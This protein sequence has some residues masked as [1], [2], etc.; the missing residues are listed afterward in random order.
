MALARK[1]AYNVVFNSTLKVVSTVFIAL[2][3]IR[4]ITGYLGQEGFGEY[5]TVLAFFA[6]FGALGDLGLAHITTREIAK[7]GAPEETI[8]GKVA[9]LR[10]ITS[11]GLI[12]L[13]PV[14]I[15]F[16]HYRHEVKEGIVIAVI[17]L[18]FSQFSSLMHSMYQKRLIMDRVAMVEFVGKGLQLGL[19]YLVVRLDLGFTALVSVLLINMAFNSVCIFWLSRSLLRFSLH[20]DRVF[21]KQFLKDALPLGAM[22]LIT[23]AYFKMDTLLLSFLRPAAEV[24]IYNVAYK[25]M[26]NLIFF[27]A[28]LAGLILPVL[29]RTHR[30]NT[31]EFQDIAR[32]TAKV[33]LIIVIPI[34]LGMFFLAGDIVAIVSGGGF[35]ASAG[36][37][38]ILAFSLAGIF[39]GHFF[40]MLILVGNVQ[41]KLMLLLLGV[42]AA[43]ISLNLV[44][45][46]HLAYRGAAIASALT[47][48]LVVLV[49]GTLVVR[50]LGFLPIPD[51][52]W[53]ILGSGLAM[54]LSL[55][56][57]TPGSFFVAGG[58]AT[59]V[60][61]G[62]LWLLKAITPTEIASVFSAKEEDPTPDHLMA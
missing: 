44:L 1:I 62:S 23:F 17:A 11:L 32:K 52:L 57:L 51:R 48:G 29:S 21:W 33:F 24:G 54:G 36:V 5:A 25:I 37:L 42:A 14:A 49:A 46:E 15:Y 47:E 18:L 34:V 16:L 55:A 7:P 43:N 59:V 53:P 41:K 56:W 50:T 8:L 20:F 6:F 4:L 13:A 12:A 26:E 60:Y 40:N 19:I 3:S 39:F 28:M 9:A 35:D 30:L 38:Q 61:V 27:P 10:L 58:V 45:I 31:H 22:A 2:L